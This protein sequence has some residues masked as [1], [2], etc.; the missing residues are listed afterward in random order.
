VIPQ[1]F[2]HLLLIV[3]AA[4]I[5]AYGIRSFKRLKR[6]I[7]AGRR[8]ARIRIYREDLFLEWVPTIALLV[9]WTLIGRGWS[10]LG[11]GP[12]AG[13]GGW[14]GAGLTILLVAVLLT[15]L[16]GVRDSADARAKLRTQMGNVAD[17]LP[18]DDEEARWFTALAITAGICEEILY[19]GFL[20]AYLGAY[21]PVAAAWALSTAAFGLAH[22]YQEI[23]GVFKTAAAGALLGGLYLL[24]GSLWAPIVAHAAYDLVAGT[25]GRLAL[26]EAAE[27]AA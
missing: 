9:F 18:H 13:R 3:L 15:Q 24:S 5:P 25:A 12:L 16:R 1:L 27:A 17:Y 10:V 14:I 6:E 21:M 4:L 11:F 22:A 8:D 19:R 20:I 7:A 26:T 2:D 23:A